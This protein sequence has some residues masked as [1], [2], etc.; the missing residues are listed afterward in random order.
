MANRLIKIATLTY[1]P[2]KPGVPAQPGRWEPY[3]YYPEIRPKKGEQSLMDNAYQSA[4]RI[5]GSS[6]GNYALDS[7]SSNGRIQQAAASSL[8]MILEAL[9]GTGPTAGGGLSAGAFP[10][11]GY[12]YVKGTPGIPEV[13]AKVVSNPQSGW[14]GGGRSIRRIRKDGRVRFSIGPRSIGVLIGL[15]GPND[16]QTFSEAT[17]AF[18]L[19]NGQLSIVESGVTVATVPGIDLADRPTFSITRIN[20]VVTY[21]VGSFSRTSAK[22]SKG[23]VYL[24]AL[25]YTAD[26]YV[27]NPVLN[28]LQSGRAED[29]F[30]LEGFIDPRA[31][32]SGDF[33]LD[34]RAA[35]RIN[36]IAKA[37]ASS[38]L[39]MP[40]TA[41][42]ATQNAGR[43]IE[44]MQLEC[45]V[46]APESRSIMYAPR[47]R[48]ISSEMTYSRSAAQHGGYQMQS[49]GGEPE[50]AVA[51]SLAQRGPGSMRSRG[52]TGVVGNSQAKH[53]GG[54]AYT[55]DSLLT[56]AGAWGK[57]TAVNGGRY[58]TIT[59]TDPYSPQEL[60]INEALLLADTQDIGNWQNLDTDE[61]LLLWVDAD[62]FIT[63]EAEA[64]ELLIISDSVS[65]LFDIE[66]AISEALCLSDS[67]T[68][69]ADGGL[70]V[71]VNMATSAS[72]F[73]QGFDYLAIRSLDSASYGV[74]PD[75]IYRLGVGL[76]ATMDAEIDFG[77]TELSRSAGRL[78][79][80]FI[81]ASADGEAYVKLTPDDGIEHT[82][83]VVQRQPI[84]RA[85]PGRGLSGRKWRL[86]LQLSE[87]TAA[88]VDMVQFVAAGSTRRGVH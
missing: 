73:Y 21:T 50:I 32:A 5:Y 22:Q 36:G 54:S 6:F 77:A 35:G 38:Y 85:D 16:S 28:E 78:Q 57:S 42:G 60:V 19:N 82:Y 20:G 45:V 66:L 37:A 29:Y 46:L 68:T 27:E 72:S 26:D 63:V 40:G 70:Q 52:I 87:V 34:G 76:G 18:Y 24:D 49:V 4:M 48:M 75:G 67:G 17:H 15:S 23:D 44:L 9:V 61:T 69:R 2:G 55:L 81:G 7:R 33:V 62:C 71:A 11:I 58:L 51:S 79:A 43:T 88:E 3:E 31:R 10:Q 14:N 59:G 30:E 74:K 80:I 64:A 13:P 41:V 1:T 39:R 83:R 56:L 53:R 65:A 47:P 8:G 84:M 25:L 86:R 12:V